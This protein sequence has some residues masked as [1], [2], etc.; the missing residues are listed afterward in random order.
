VVLQLPSFIAQ[1]NGDRPSVD[2][3]AKLRLPTWD[4]SRCLY[5]Y[6]YI[7]SSLTFLGWG[8]WKKHVFLKTILFPTRLL[9]TGG[10]SRWKNEDCQLFLLRWSLLFPLWAV[11]M[12]KSHCGKNRGFLDQG[13]K[14]LVHIFTRWG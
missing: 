11:C 10:S 13:S 3:P 7:T 1:N 14:S 9:D 12:V 5:L 8:W 4:G 2:F 6:N